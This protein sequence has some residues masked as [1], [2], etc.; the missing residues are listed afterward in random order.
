MI[1][2]Q[3]WEDPWIRRVWITEIGSLPCFWRKVRVV[4][5]FTC[6]LGLFFILLSVTGQVMR[7][8]VY[9]TNRDMEYLVTREMFLYIV[10]P[11]CFKMEVPRYLCSPSGWITRSQE[12]WEIALAFKFWPLGQSEEVAEQTGFI[13]QIGRVISYDLRLHPFSNLVSHFPI[14]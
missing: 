12:K 6:S 2:S 5:L 13:Q 10:G 4:W 3:E 9:R 8:W 14:A 11:G 1:S 7:V